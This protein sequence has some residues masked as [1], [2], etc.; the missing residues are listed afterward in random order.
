MD[1]FKIGF[2]G[3]LVKQSMGLC[4]SVWSVSCSELF[5]STFLVLGPMRTGAAISCF[6]MKCFSF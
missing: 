3:E 5:Y 4:W 6:L 2:D 1:Y